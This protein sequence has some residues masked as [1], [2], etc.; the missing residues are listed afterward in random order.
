MYI[1]D[2][3]T[4]KQLLDQT[5]IH[6][7]A[8][9]PLPNPNE[10]SFAIN[11]LLRHK[12]PIIITLMSQEDIKSFYYASARQGLVGPTHVW[13]NASP[14]ANFKGDNDTQLSNYTYEER[15]I[16][17]KG[18]IYFFA[19]NESKTVASTRF[20]S[21]YW[22]IFEKHYNIKREDTLNSLLFNGEQQYDCLKAMI[23][24]MKTHSQA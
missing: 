18:F 1:Q 23:I 6:V 3:S 16:L 4:L 17:G 7:T 2:D 11:T 13:I 20:A 14:I 22:P 19:E 15:L 8:N 21:L 9:I 24:G 10:P 5:T 12:T